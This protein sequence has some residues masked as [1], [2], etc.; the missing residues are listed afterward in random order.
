MHELGHEA[1]PWDERDGFQSDVDAHIVVAPHEFFFLGEGEK[2]RNGP[3]PDNVILICTE[4][5]STSWFA[6]ARECVSR[7]AAVWDID[8]GAAAHF[9]AQGIPCEY[10]PLGYVPGFSELGHVAR[11]PEHYGTCFLAPDVR[12]AP[13]HLAPASGRPLDLLF[14]GTN[15]PRREAFFARSAPFLADYRSYFHLSPLNSPHIDNKTTYMNTHT[16]VGLSQRAKILLNIHHGHDTYFEWHRI[17]MHGLWHKTLVV[18]E[19]CSAAAPFHPGVD[20]IEA[21]LED[22]PR[23]LRYY[24]DDP[25]GRLEA[26]AI[27]DSGHRTL[28]EDCRLASTLRALLCSASTNNAF[29]S[30]LN[31]DS[32]CHPFSPPTL[33]QRSA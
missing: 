24:L 12:R 7:A 16:A 26:Q 32:S 3:W 4:Q 25:R 9:R 20:Y 18:S 10:L 29:L 28:V 11:L 19:P 15:T 2:L 27:A 17:V 33:L 8:R 13:E 23:V 1:L 5:P 22:F 31:S 6:R 21:P 14:I 30:Q